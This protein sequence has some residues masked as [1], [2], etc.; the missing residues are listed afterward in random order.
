MI[1]M[2][3]PYSR[4]VV[5][6]PIVLSTSLWVFI[7]FLAGMFFFWTQDIS[8]SV[9]WQGEGLLTVDEVVDEANHGPHGVPRGVILLSLGGFSAVSLLRSGRNPLRINGGLGLLII[10]FMVWAALSIAW[11]DDSVMA[12]KRVVGF[13]LLALSALAVAERF[14][15]RQ[16]MV[17]A[18]V[19]CGLFLVVGV[20]AEIAMGTFHIFQSD[21]RFCGT[22][23]PN[24]GSWGISTL[25]LAA[26]TLA[27]TADK[28]RGIFWATASVALAFLL[29]SRT[30]TSFAAVI[31]A[32]GSFWFLVSSRPRKLAFI[33]GLIFICCLGYLVLGDELIA[34]A[35]HGIMLGREGTA[36]TGTDASTLTGRTPVWYECF[37]YIAKRPLLGYG[38]DCFWTPQRVVEITSAISDSTAVG[39][40][41][42]SYID[43]A[44]GVGVVGAGAYVLMLG[45][46]IK[47]SIF[48]FKTSHNPD[49]AFVCSLLIFYCIVMLTEGIASAP[50]MTQFTVLAL[51]AHLGFVNSPACR[52]K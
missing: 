33:L 28:H 13:A 24:V 40:A 11:A 52:L 10:F 48:L 27:S 36:G 31:L 46:A 50:T 19:T 45:L 47:K 22:D 7:A 39:W 4:T 12:L 51:L 1:T 15:V 5:G 9:R 20:F 2:K 23:D 38:Y 44:L 32:L 34:Y 6:S 29:L 17:L 21:Y 8:H 16:V 42:N 35:R 43:L 3:E 49:Y 25:L 30:R 18:F 14:S 41:F 26:I 37:L